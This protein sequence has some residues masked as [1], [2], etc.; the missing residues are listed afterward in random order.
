MKIGDRVEI[1]KSSEF[2]GQFIGSM[3]ISRIT[4]PDSSGFCIYVKQGTYTN[5]YRK[6]DLK[7]VKAIKIKDIGKYQTPIHNLKV[8]A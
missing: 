8:I 3:T 4:N 5:G 1:R 6:A 7:L 2:H